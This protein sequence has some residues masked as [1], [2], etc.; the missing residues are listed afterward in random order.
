MEVSQTDIKFAETWLAGPFTWPP[1]FF[2]SLNT[3]C[4]LATAIIQ[5]FHDLISVLATYYTGSMVQAPD[6][7]R[8]IWDNLPNLTC[9]TNMKPVPPA[10]GMI[11]TLFHTIW[12]LIGINPGYVREFFSNHGTTNVFTI[13]TSMLKCDFQGVTYCSKH[14]KDLLASIVLILLLYVILYYAA[15]AIG[16]SVLGSAIIMVAAFIPLLLWYSYGMAFTCSPMLPTCLLDDVVYTLS[17]LFPLQITFPVELQTSPDC[18][19]DSSKDSCLLRCSE[20]PVEFTEWRDTLAFGICYTSQALCTSLAGAIGDKDVLSVKLYATLE[21][22]TNA[23]PSR[24]N[25]SLFCFG[26]TFVTV[27]PVILLLIVGVT[28][29]VYVLYLPCAFAPKLVALI[30]QYLVYLH[31][32]SKDD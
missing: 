24:I 13:S 15:S 27:I 14:R 19:G 4:N 2:K 6:P 32:S 11:S 12:D 17:A 22:L 28:V 5:I 25:A 8:G 16:L 26:V 21:L 30:G 29:S 31:T 3:Q 20:P 10:N 1:P 7:P 9:S 18:L 23:Q